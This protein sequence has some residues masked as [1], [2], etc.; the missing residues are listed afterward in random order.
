MKLIINYDK[1]RDYLDYNSPG[2]EKTFIYLD[3]KIT[4]TDLIQRLQL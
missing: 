3:V 2:G 4:P 1:L